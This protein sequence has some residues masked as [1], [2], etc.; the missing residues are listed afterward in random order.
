MSLHGQ[1]GDDPESGFQLTAT[2]TETVHGTV[3][4]IDF[5]LKRLDLPQLARFYATTLPVEIRSGL[6]SISGSIHLAETASG[7][8]S[9][10]LESFELGPTT[11]RPLFGLPAAT[12]ERV[13]EGINRYA[14]EVPIVFGA[15]IEGSADAPAIAW[16]APLLEIAREGLM[17]AG[18]RELNRTILELGDRI[19]GLGG[20]EEIPLDPSFQSVQQVTESAAHNLIES[21][22]GGLLQDLPA[23]GDATED[24]T[25]SDSD[26]AKDL[27]DL[28]PGLLNKLLDSASQNEDTEDGASSSE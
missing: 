9:F 16:E 12:S 6:A 14:D 7:T 4:T 25:D 11:G 26:N 8:L 19:E 23:L 15:L 20:L 13:I 18:K 2:F 22:G 1:W 21:V 27:L 10:L 3:S 17:M 28:L 5:A 24:E